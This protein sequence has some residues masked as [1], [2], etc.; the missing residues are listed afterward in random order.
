MLD[1]M[2]I[3]GKDDQE[4]LQNLDKVLARLEEYG[5]PLNLAVLVRML[6]GLSLS[7]MHLHNFGPISIVDLCVASD[8]TD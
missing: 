8:V 5:L 1:D 2:A 7:E 6:Q 4:H 3:T